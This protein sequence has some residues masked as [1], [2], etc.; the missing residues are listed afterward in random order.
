MV[1]AERAVEQFKLSC[2]GELCGF[3]LVREGYCVT[4]GL[5]VQ[6]HAHVLLVA[7]ELFKDLGE[8]FLRLVAGFVVLGQFVLTSKA[9]VAA[10]SV[11]VLLPGAPCGRLGVAGKLSSSGGLR[12]CVRLCVCFKPALSISVPLFQEEK[13]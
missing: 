1:W 12:S 10:G 4:L 2:L 6:L 7:L 5:I 8:F 13:K 9:D 11:Q 3:F